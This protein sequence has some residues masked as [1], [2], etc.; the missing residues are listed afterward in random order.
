M[1]DHAHW[2]WMDPGSGYLSWY[3]GPSARQAYASGFESDANR[4]V[5]AV[6]PDDRTWHTLTRPQFER[7]AERLDAVQSVDE[8]AQMMYAEVWSEAD[9][10]ADLMAGGDRS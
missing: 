6:S 1:S 10:F 2:R 8:I 9:L 5:V 3:Y 7:L 4:F